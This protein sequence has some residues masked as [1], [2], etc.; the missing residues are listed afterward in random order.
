MSILSMGP[1]YFVAL[2][3]IFL[4]LYG[5]FSSQPIWPYFL[6]FSDQKFGA[7]WDSNSQSG[8]HLRMLGIC[9][10]H[11]CENVF[12]SQNTLLVCVFFCVLAL[13][14]NLKLGFQ[15]VFFF[16]KTLKWDSR[17]Y[18]VINPIIFTVHKLSCSY[19]NWKLS[20]EYIYLSRIFLKSKC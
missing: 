6:S 5:T 3:K 1:H 2:L 16:L 8:S 10:F 13:V 14:L 20:Q 17:N 12:N 19:P 15:Q 11:I 9:I 4:M 7:F 18:Q